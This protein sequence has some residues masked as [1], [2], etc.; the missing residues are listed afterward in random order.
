MLF[1]LLIV[2]AVAVAVSCCHH[3]SG[4]SVIESAFARAD[5]QRWGDDGEQKLDARRLRDRL[6]CKSLVPF[7]VDKLIVARVREDRVSVCMCVLT[8]IYLFV[9]AGGGERD[10]SAP[11][12]LLIC[13]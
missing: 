7:L 12:S 9:A 5:Q 1:V 11:N 4:I 3:R 2:V 13:L 10:Y 8:C 6:Y